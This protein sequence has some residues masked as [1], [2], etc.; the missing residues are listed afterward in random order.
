MSVSHVYTII[1]L[2]SNVYSTAAD[3]NSFGILYFSSS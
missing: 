1:I 2:N 3:E